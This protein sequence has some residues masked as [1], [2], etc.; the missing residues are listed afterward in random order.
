MKQNLLFNQASALGKRLAMV[1]TML[2]TVGIGQA[3]GAD[4]ELV[5]SAPSDWSGEY[6][7]V[8]G[9]SA[10]S[11]GTSSWGTTT[12]VTVSNNKISTTA[13]I[14]VT[15]SKGGTSGTY[16]IYMNSNSK[17]L[18]EVTSNTFATADASSTDTEW[19]ISLSNGNAQ[20]ACASA[21]TRY[22]RLNGTSGYRCYT[23]ATGTL[24]KLYKKA[25]SYTITAQ[26]NNTTYGTVSL[27]ETTITASPKTGYR[28]S[29]TTPYT[30]SPSEAATVIQSENKFTVTP[31]ANCTITINFEAKPKYT[32]TLKDDN[33][34]LIQST[35][36]G[37]VTL[38]S[39][40][41]CDG[42]E[43]VGWTKTWTSDQTSW[44]T[45]APTIIPD[46]SYTP[47][48]NENLYPVY[49]KTG[50]TEA[51]TTTTDYVLTDL[52]N[53]KSTDIVVIT[54]YHS[55]NGTY[56]MSNNNGTSSAPTAKSVTVSG[57]KLSADP[58]TNYK[59]NISNNNGNLTIYPNGT[60]STWLYCTS[61]NNGVRVG[62]NANKTFTISNDYLKHTGTSRYLGVYN[63]QDWRCYTSSTVNIDNQELK[64]Y[65]ETTTTTTTSTTTTSYISV[66]D[67][68]TETVVSFDL[69]GGSGTFDDVTLD[70]TTYVI[71]ETEPTY[72]GYNFTGW[73]IQ[74]GDNTVYKYGTTNSTINNIT[75][76]ITLVAQWSAIE[77]TITYH[78]NGGSGVENTTY[79][80]ESED[81]TLP[82]PE[83]Q[84]LTFVGWYESADFI[85]DPVTVIKSGSTGNKEFW[86][87]WEKSTPTFEWSAATCTVTIASE[88]NVF[89]TLETTPVD[90]AGVKYS[91][92]NTDVAT[93][94]ANGNIILK[95][96]G[97]TTIRAYYEE[98]DTYAAAED[99]Y[100]LTVKESTNCR[101]EEVTIDDIEY[102]DEVVVVMAH[103]LDLYALP[104]DKETATNSNPLAIK[105][106]LDDFKSTIN[107]TCIW[108][109]TKEDEG[110]SFTLSPKTATNKYLTC[111][112][113]NNAVR[114]NTASERNF[115]IENGFLKNIYYS[116]FLAISTNAAQKDWRHYASTNTTISSRAQTLK[117]Y[118]RVCL[119]EGQYWVKWMVNGQE[120]T[121]GSPTTMVVAGGQVVTLP[122]IPD[123]YQL[124]GCTSKKFIGWTSDEI[125]VETDDA[126]TMFTDAASSPAIYTNQ[127]FHA[128]FA[129]VEEGEEGWAQV[130]TTDDLI[131]GDI[132]TIGSSSTAGD[133]KVLGAQQS[134]NR[135]AVS[136]NS[137]NL[138]ELTLGES[139]GAW[140]L[141]DGT[142]Y[143]YAAS[144]SSNHL[145][146]QETN[147]AN[148][149]WSINFSTTT[150]K[151]SAIIVAQ[152]SNSRNVLRYNVNSGGDPLFSCYKDSEQMAAIYLFKKLPGTTFSGYVTQC[153]TPWEA[154][155]LSAS[156]SSITVGENT[157]ITHSGTAYGVVTY[158][159]NDNAI[160]TVD[161]NGV[162]T[163]VKP[164]KVTITATWDG[165]NGVNNYCPAEAT[166]D[167]TVTGSFTITYDANHAS[168]TGATTATTITYPYGS[169]T[170]ANNGF[171]LDGHEFV[172]WNTATDGSGDDYTEGASITLTDN[173]TLY[174]IW[175]PN[176]YDVTV[177]VIGGSVKL[178]TTTITTANTPQTITDV[179][180]HGQ[181]FSFTNATPDAE[182]ETPYAI[183][184]VS[185]TATVTSNSLTI[186]NVQSDLEITIEY[187]LKPVYTITYIIPE[188]G[189]E[190][191]ADA[192]TS[193]YKGG[194]ITL[195][196]IKDGTI[197]SEYSCEEF[198][199][200]TTLN[201]YE[202]Y[203]GAMPTP[204]YNAG[205]ELSGIT[206]ATTL[207]PVYKR[208]GDGPSGTVELTCT[209]VATWKSDVLSGNNNSYGTVTTRSATDGSEWKTNGLIQNAGGISLKDNYYI[210]IPTLPGPMTTITM[211]VS[212]QNIGS[213]E[214][215]CTEHVASATSRTF[216]F[217]SK[218]DGSNLFSSNSVTEASRSRTIEITEGNYTT[219]YIINGEGTSH[220]HAITVAY[221]SPNII[222]TK[223]KCTNDIDEF[224]ITYN[225]N[226]GSTRGQI[227]TGTVVNGACDNSGEPIRF[228]DLPNGEY[229]ICNSLT[230]TQYKLVGWN[231]QAN[232]NGGLSYEPGD[233]ITMVPQSDITLYAQWVPEVIM[234]DNQDRT[235]TYQETVEEAI[236]LPVGAYTCDGKY[237]FVGWT[238][239]N[240]DSWNQKI[241]KPTLVAELDGN[242]ETLFVPTE[243]TVVYA[244]YKLEST[245]NS[246]AFYLKSDNNFY[247][248][249]HNT[250]VLKGTSNIADATRLYRQQINVE[251]PNNYWLYYLD[252]EQQKR[253]VYINTANLG[254]LYIPSIGD[255]ETT[256]E[257]TKG[258]EFV[259]V[260]G[261][262]K[263]KALGT[264]GNSVGIV[265]HYMHTN[266]SGKMGSNITGSVYTIETATEINYYAYPT[267]SDEITITFETRGGTLIPNDHPYVLTK[268]EGDVITLPGCEYAGLDFIGWVN[269]PIEPTEIIA[270]PEDIYEAEEEYVVGDQNIVLYAYY[271]Q[272][273]ESAEYDGNSDGEWKI[274][275][276]ADGE[277]HFAVAPN[278]EEGDMSTVT[279]CDKS[280]TWTFTNVAENQYH[281]QDEAGR[282]VG[283]RP[284][285]E[286]KNDFR[287]TDEPVIWTIES[288][289]ND[290][291]RLTCETN[292]DRVMLYDNGR[293]RYSS[294]TQ[295]GKSG[296]FYVTIGG[297][298]N[299]I[300][301]TDPARLQAVSV[302]GTVQITST[303][304]QTVKAMDKLTLV[305]R[306]AE[307]ESYI[308][309]SSPNVTFYDE[310][311]NVITTALVESQKQQ[312]PLVVAYTPDVADNSIVRPAITV[313]AKTLNQSTGTYVETNYSV[314]GRISAR[315]LPA[316]FVIA[317]KTGNSWVALTAN[318]TSTG[319]QAAPLI[320]VDNIDLPTK[321]TI[322]PN[323]TKYQ[324]LGLQTDKPNIA[325]SRFKNN[326]A[327]V[328]LYSTNVSKVISASTSTDNNKT[329][330]NADAAHE[331]AANSS[332][333]LFYEWQLQTN[334][335]VHYTLVN[336]NTTNTSN[337]KLGYSATYA[338]WG[339]YQTGNN[340]IQEVLLLP[341]EKDI[342]EMDVEVMEWG[343]NS[344][345]LRFGSEAP[346][347]VDITLGATTTKGLSLAN[348]NSGNTSD[349]YK[350][351]GLSLAGNDCEAL[352]ITDATDASKGKL[353]RKPILVSGDK[354]G[355][356][357]TTAPTRD[358]CMHSDIVIL[359][360]GKLTADEAK[361]VGSHVDFAN[362]YVY[363]G[364][365]LVLDD[366]SLGVKRQ[367]YLRGGYSW[368]N[369]TYALPEVYVNDDI[370]FNGSGNMIYDY[371][372]QN[373]KYYQFALPYDVQLAK[374][375]DESGADNFP[376]WVKHYNG[377]LRAADAYATSWEWY[378]SEG[379]D[380]NA[381]FEAGIGYIIAAKP[382]QVGNVANR[383]LSIIRFPLSNDA[384]TGGEGNKSVDTKAHG[385]EGYKAGTVT[386]NNVG[387]NFIGNPF[388]ATWKGDIGHKELAKHPDENNWD[389]S[390][391]WVDSDVKFITIMSPE[392]GSD[393][394]QTRA[395]DADLKPFFPFYIQET[396][397]GGSGTINF[398]AANR[399]KKAP[400][401]WN[402]EQDEREAYI[403]IEIV[404]D[405]VTDQTGVFVSNKYSDEI[406][407]DDYEKMFGSSTDKPKVW[408]VHDNTRLAFEAMTENRAIGITPLGYRAPLE[409][410]YM[411]VLNDE[412][413]QLDNVESIY[414]TDYETGVTDYDLTSSA[415]EFESTTTLYNDT[416]FAIR[417]V[418][419]D[420][421]QGS[422]TAVDN[423]GTGDEQIY[424]FIYRDKI[425]ILHH[426]VIYDATGKQVI[427]INK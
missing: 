148:G 150:P 33:S 252:D 181:S 410:E 182:Y 356:D 382:R 56:A 235:I 322:T 70:G 156:P 107:N 292:T 258:W 147:N 272:T 41:G 43:F 297:C 343:T 209:D 287:F 249:K 119:P 348:L 328:H 397:D 406:D 19:K 90:L 135:A 48:A 6:L 140:T 154:P 175:Q 415:Y 200:W 35:A 423:V 257:D 314:N 193:I 400:A 78:L 321:A 66:P 178:K 251:S 106:T 85:G 133:G 55:T 210:Q 236:T 262:Y 18:K 405:A 219:G 143:L 220:V 283:V 413:S 132:Y 15:I 304:G 160:A 317:A 206:E 190:L 58:G 126:P 323:T 357:Y 39:R 336:S 305:V 362:I 128:L 335:L 163:G 385:I 110:S 185:G 243:P 73:K 353:I 426:G 384:F 239:D 111:N 29:T 245:A 88:S 169:G 320:M 411:L 7:I 291:Y 71:P 412:V 203:V 87:K 276:F 207:R 263:L 354:K 153:C 390:Y 299:P 367:V 42:Y 228:E 218:A 281:I 351:E 339:M 201:S 284:A 327:A 286:D 197:S 8:A 260:T 255:G 268:K 302:Y 34:T 46:G 246:K 324:L 57:S 214:D 72:N 274:Y 277:Y 212:Q 11:G 403:Q 136:W 54:T 373:Q 158:T 63:K 102:G 99:T 176:Q 144:S 67:C 38:P 309:F 230:A 248:Q 5:T 195:P 350:V 319:T 296:Y 301:T 349:I 22:L 224:T 313:T 211:K 80:I 372:I 338:Q 227:P 318:I 395:V 100:T 32:V 387:W 165:V 101:W 261:G 221:G 53:I 155:T 216:Y 118:K 191:A 171:A 312:I 418:M 393:Y 392:D 92:S 310:S 331:G 404:M 204:F 355:S 401:L 145:K 242:D 417:V 379:G 20:I 192:V 151:G 12:T 370:N 265:T 93:I 330:I 98:D 83:K 134:N 52:A 115:T 138:V 26:S 177:T 3:W 65:V 316:D 368:L 173:L 157:T 254:N 416:R 364:G 241:T 68:A 109:I 422:V 267:C 222:S 213:G 164:G 1:L 103:G 117:F 360:G 74:G 311:G 389:G 386:A 27:S 337:T 141:S 378:P 294:H 273:P 363:P 45:T 75:E 289:G 208:N 326:G 226:Y 62:T 383:P 325:D 282:Y 427:T 295:E 271:S 122:I 28:V 51:T 131:A 50:T 142:G 94:D 345:A 183:T 96:A 21:T 266:E 97:E 381:Y 77:Y 244:V 189:G 37:S 149:T 290:L 300:Y 234:L 340:V 16:Y 275:A 202:S 229:T 121:V 332:N 116:T 358:V 369:S 17:Y 346:A 308:R 61:A 421:T 186:S 172:K 14:S 170:V 409:S 76:S 114:I 250:Y 166:I 374:V 187:T 269:E 146:T 419:R 130:T 388:M 238:T 371:Y 278:S 365:K 9:T 184:L 247:A 36:G 91:S 13:N 376:V 30:I 152:G 233:V 237:T 414:L 231:S 298:F 394:A 23:S 2:L 49:T 137:G 86:A 95:S 31:T 425:Y 342:T 307:P 40:E 139:T 402:V 123:D 225:T 380:A 424:K 196:G 240:V 4:Y 279:I 223:L 69:N 82:T 104:Y 112:S 89:P 194:S 161:A 288:K 303:L 79:T 129:D 399:V 352:L 396:A 361:T 420:N 124:P 347:T 120:Y 179:V 253:F 59:W 167:I 407:F 174:A 280:T 60:T 377:A 217:R 205:D 264:Y 10:L 180:A 44:T 285:I 408:L 315:S 168:A 47:T 232:G 215:A 199:G 391:H 162:V 64:F 329:Y 256:P 341:I 293:I 259:S 84:G 398:A 359:N 25:A 113:S 125:L 375:T 108:Y 188:G 81:I 24:P 127:T 344:M 105:I 270:N 333:C 159:S 198:I 334:D 366:K 306:H